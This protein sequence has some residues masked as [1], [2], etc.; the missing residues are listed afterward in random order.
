M[1]RIES[2]NAEG[3][4]TRSEERSEEDER[5]KTRKMDTNLVG[6]LTIPKQLTLTV[7]K[8]CPVVM[9]ATP[10]TNPIQIGAKMR[11]ELEQSQSERQDD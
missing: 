9:P 4:E 3:K 7:S 11:D 5:K 6:K 8:G 10:A 1:K 2:V